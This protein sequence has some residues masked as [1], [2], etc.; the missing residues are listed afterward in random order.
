MIKPL[1]SLV[2]LTLLGTQLLATTPYANSED[3]QKDLIET[4]HK[5]SMDLLKTL[6]KNM[7]AH[8]KKEGPIGAA[9]FCNVQAY[10]LTDTVSNKYGK[11]ISVKRI[12]LKYRNPANKPEGSEMNIM[13]ALQTLKEN[14]AKLPPYILQDADADTV[15]Y[16]KPLVIT[17]G[18]CLKCH[19]NIEGSKIGNFMKKNYPEDKATH[20][21]MGDLRG[22]VVVTIKK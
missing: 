9:Q 12:S 11:D 6:G 18:V 8:M 14:G 17:K 1:L 22:A 10:P 20:Y 2:T 5:V 7:K 15:K 3:N 21:K 19:G 4:G 13:I 16:Y